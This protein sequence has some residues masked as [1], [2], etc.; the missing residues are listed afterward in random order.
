MKYLYKYPQA[1]FPYA[2]ARRGEPRA[3]GAQRR[4]TSCSTP[5]CS[6][7]TATSTCSSN[8]RRPTPTISSSASRRDNRGPEPAPLDVLPTVWFRNTW[9][10]GTGRHG[11]GS[12]DVPA[13]APTHRAATRTELRPALAPLRRSAAS[14]CSPRTRPT[15][16]GCSASTTIALRQGRLQRLHRRRRDDAVNPRRGGTKAA[17]HYALDDRAGRD[18]RRCGCGSP[19]RHARSR[20]AVRPDFDQIFDERAS[21]GGRVLRR[22]DPAADLSADA[23][24]GAC[25]RRSP[26]M[27]WSK[28]F[29]HYVV[30]DWLEGD[31]AQPPPPRGAAARAQPRVDAP[32]QRRRDLDA[33][34]VGVP[35]VRRVGPGV[36]LRAAGAGRFR[37]RE[38]A[39]RAAPARMVHAPQRAAARLRMGARRRESAGACVGGA[40]ASTRS[41]RSGAAP[42]IAHSSSASFTSCC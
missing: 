35:L 17:A 42:A 18:G 11:R 37:L 30:S 1:A 32:L 10:W 6:P 25:A 8:T 13:S 20:G 12:R 7:T 28:Q 3:A 15:P 41:R 29:Y 16:S 38:G 31:P 9:S 22:R 14:C 39:A 26:G 36:P 19:T 34:Q 2:R 27:L 4:S 33:G 40:G 23:R 24:S 5:A 21:R